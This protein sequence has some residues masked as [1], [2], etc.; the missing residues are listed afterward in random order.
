MNEMK[1]PPQNPEDDAPRTAV[2][3]TLILAGDRSDNL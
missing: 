1:H 3:E 2:W